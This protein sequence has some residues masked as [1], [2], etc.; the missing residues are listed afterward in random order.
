MT[1]YVSRGCGQAYGLDL[2]GHS[3]A[4][5]SSWLG[6]PKPWAL[7][8]TMTNKGCRQHVLFYWASK[9]LNTEMGRAGKGADVDTLAFENGRIRETT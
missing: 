1:G 6:L 3:S 5:V 7:A 2:G 8:S 9:A 4:Q